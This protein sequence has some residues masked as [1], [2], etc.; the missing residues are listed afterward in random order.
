MA[1]ILDLLAAL[2]RGDLPPLPDPAKPVPIPYAP[3][4][5]GPLSTDTTAAFGALNPEPVPPAITPPT[6]PDADFINQY[7]G[8]A[9][10]APAPLSRGQRIANALAGF[11][12]GFQGNGAQF[13]AQLQEPQREYQRQLERYE[14]R[15][16]QGLE[17][18]ERRA[19]DQA[20]RANRAAELQYERE[21]KTWL[22]KMDIRQDEADVRTK[23]AFELLKQREAE[24]IADEKLREQQAQQT[25]I[26]LADLTSKYR[27]LGAKDMATE[28]ARKDLDPNYK[29]SPRAEKWY[30]ARVALD[31][32]RANRAAGLGGG[33][34][35]G[36]SARAQ[37]LADEIQS[38]KDKMVEAEARGDKQTV[39]QLNTR[40]KALIRNAG[41]FPQIEAG[42]DPTGKWPYVKVRGAQPT[43]P[44]APQGQQSDPLGI[45]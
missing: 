3:T 39:K 35:G 10:T 7:A 28:L 23:Q 42:F 18:A 8:P 33:T 14:G 25:K 43:P 21:Y 6:A 31:E 24:R 19:Q 5:L 26:K 45:R 29:L 11:G 37:K 44:T 15:R 20:D 4:N 41:R 1:T 13:L 38:V 30:S 40:A 36:A 27:A 22:K 17:I 32:A 12:A 9:P 2:N 16:T 34:G